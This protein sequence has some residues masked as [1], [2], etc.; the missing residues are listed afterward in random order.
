MKNIN[1][2]LRGLWRGLGALLLWLVACVGSLVAMIACVYISY[3]HTMELGISG[4]LDNNKAFAYVI[5][6]ETVFL[7]S[8]LVIIFKR[9]M[10]AYVHWGVYS[11]GFVA[12]AINGWGNVVAGIDHGATG[13]IIGVS[14]PLLA[15]L[16]EIVLAASLLNVKA[17]YANIKTGEDNAKNKSGELG[18]KTGVLEW[19]KIALTKLVAKEDAEIK[20]P[21]GEVATNETANTETEIAIAKQT[22]KKTAKV[23]EP[24]KKIALSPVVETKPA[25]TTEHKTSNLDEEL[26]ATMAKAAKEWRQKNGKWP[27]RDKLAAKFGVKP[28][29]ARGVIDKLKLAE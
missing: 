20:T 27:S 4:G 23:V 6:V 12:L 8:A 16:A 14:V 2:L 9:M 25:T 19:A 10:K 21:I 15:I 3:G 1:E 24:A 22:T 29:T 18:E 26:K 11:A 13:V 17:A 28:A 5:L 7:M